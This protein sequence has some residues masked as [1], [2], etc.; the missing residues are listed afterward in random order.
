MGVTIASY[1]GY[2]MERDQLQTVW[3]IK[4][5]HFICD[6]SKRNEFGILLVYVFLVYF[7]CHQQNIL[8]ATP[9][10]DRLITS[11]LWSKT[12]P[13]LTTWFIAPEIAN[14]RHVGTLMLSGVSNWP[15]G[16]PAINGYVFRGDRHIGGCRLRLPGFITT[17]ARVVM[18]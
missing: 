6:F 15:V 5:A 3:T 9:F 13:I 4:C 18:P 8:V 16:L 1:L 14:K 17:S 12:K 11:I 10:Y 2:T 7:V